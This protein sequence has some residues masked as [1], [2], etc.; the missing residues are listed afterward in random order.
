MLGLGT[1]ENYGWGFSPLP[2]S[3]KNV[4]SDSHTKLQSN[5]VLSLSVDH[6]I[7]TDLVFLTAT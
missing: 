4:F 3:Y 6:P 1:L 5:M 2:K 7:N